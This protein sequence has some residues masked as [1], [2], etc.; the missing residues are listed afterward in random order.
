[1]ITNS[2]YCYCR[3]HPAAEVGDLVAQKRAELESEL[4]EQASTKEKSVAEALAA[5][6][7]QLLK[8]GYVG[9]PGMNV[10]CLPTMLASQGLTSGL[11]AASQAESLVSNL[12]GACLLQEIC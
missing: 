7:A 6:R 12:M 2:P 8:E 4:Q 9:V 1:M 5:Y 11:F 10:H 3:R